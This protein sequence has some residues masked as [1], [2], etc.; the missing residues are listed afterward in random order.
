LVEAKIRE[1]QNLNR[2]TID[3][4]V[5]SSILKVGIVVVAINNHMAFIQV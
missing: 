3:K 5:S 2:T 1:I 4:Q